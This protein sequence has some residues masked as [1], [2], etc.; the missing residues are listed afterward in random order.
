MNYTQLFITTNKHT[1]AK[2]DTIAGWVREFL[3]DAGLDVV[4]FVPKPVGEPDEEETVKPTSHTCRKAASSHAARFAVPMEEIMK[5]AGWK[6][7]ETFRKHYDLPTQSC[8]VPQAILDSVKPKP[9]KKA[10]PKRLRKSK[11][12]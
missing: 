5:S 1:P 8:P 12:N 10:K 3:E 7:A 2:R 4:R 9:A 11:I 6:N